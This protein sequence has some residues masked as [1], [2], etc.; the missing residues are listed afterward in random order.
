MTDAP[1][2]SS[3]TGRVRLA[4]FPFV[5]WRWKMIEHSSTPKNLH[6]LLV[7]MREWAYRCHLEMLKISL[8]NESYARLK[9]VARMG[10]L[11]EMVLRCHLERPMLGSESYSEG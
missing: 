5:T 1:V 8:V 11:S 4:C 10:E 6:S 7:M 2:Q 3:C 9:N